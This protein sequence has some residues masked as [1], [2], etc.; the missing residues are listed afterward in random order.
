MRNVTAIEK[1]HP[2]ELAVVASFFAPLTGSWGLFN[3]LE[4]NKYDQGQKLTTCL[5]CS[6]RSI[7]IGLT[8]RSF[9]ELFG[10]NK[11]SA[12]KSIHIIL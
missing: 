10:Q 9:P 2:E 3:H 1:T 4:E 7:T 11:Q 12:M 8:L 6:F 5:F